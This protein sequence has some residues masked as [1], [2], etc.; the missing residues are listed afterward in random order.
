M[1]ILNTTLTWGLV[2]KV[3]HW[4]AALL[5]L[6][7]VITGF[8]RYFKLVSAETWSIFYTYWHMPAGVAI[9]GLVIF[10]ILWRFSQPHPELPH[11][12]RWWERLGANGVHLYLYVAMVFMP[13]TGW[14]GF[15]ALKIE[16]NPLGF[17]LPHLFWDIR[18]LSFI[19]EDIHLYLA[20][21]LMLAL[22]LH[23]GAALKHHF[24]DG[25]QTLRRMLPRMI[26]RMIP[27][28]WMKSQ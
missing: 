2:S 14:I 8:L 26:P 11:D 17:N 15:N 21:G 9:L 7:Q 5:I 16:V 1:T 23:I 18:P 6:A 25:D 20:I 27:G 19:M 12:M 24:I 22:G 13:L 28:G 3:L 10:R 4:T